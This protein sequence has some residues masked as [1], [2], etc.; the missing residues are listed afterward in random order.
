MKPVGNV[1]NAGNTGVVETQAVEKKASTVVQ[2]ETPPEEEMIDFGDADDI[3]DAM[4][5]FDD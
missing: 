3:S 4:N 1:G 2:I 5:F